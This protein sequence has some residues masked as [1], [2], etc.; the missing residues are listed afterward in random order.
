MTRKK[1]ERRISPK[2]A[3]SLFFQYGIERHI[4]TVRRMCVTGELTGARK[5]G[6]NWF[7]PPA[8]VRKL[9]GIEDN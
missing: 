5:I 2:E 8:A 7:I 1:M 6:Q 3:Q 4:E 9:A